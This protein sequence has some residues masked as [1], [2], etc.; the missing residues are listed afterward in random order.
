MST[1]VEHNFEDSASGRR[2]RQVLGHGK[3]PPEALLE[4]VR[5]AVR[6]ALPHM[7]P[8]HGYTT[9]K[10][11]GPVLWA[12]WKPGEHISAGICLSYLVS[13]REVPLVRHTTRS[14]SGTR[15]YF[16]P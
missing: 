2:V 15:K 12:A 1:F 8:R 10:I 16:L 13:I 11:C 3:T 5:K 6:E 7:T 4:V 9:K 14:G